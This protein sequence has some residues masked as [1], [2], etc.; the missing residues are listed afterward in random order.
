M[1]ERK[2]GG[3]RGKERESILVEI[4]IHTFQQN[5]PVREL[6]EFRIETKQN[7]RTK[8]IGMAKQIGKTT[9]RT[10]REAEERATDGKR[11]QR[12]ENKEGRSRRQKGAR[13]D[14]KGKKRREGKKR[15]QNNR[16]PKRQAGRRDAEDQIRGV[17]VQNRAR[18]FVYERF[19]TALRLVQRCEHTQSTHEKHTHTYIYIY[20][21]IYVY[22]YIISTQY[23]R[24]GTR[25]RRG[26][27]E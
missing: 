17:L 25:R 11:E 16:R 20:I 12:R 7:S 27:G 10:R 3:E 6:R 21:Y 24:N 4:P 9:E 14:E 8:N 18:H 23:L 5:V 22:I 13:S 15:R 2:E 19:I 26:R 1:E